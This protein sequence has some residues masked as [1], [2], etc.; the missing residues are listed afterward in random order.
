MLPAQVIAHFSRRQ[1]AQQPTGHV[2]HDP[3]ACR[4]SAESESPGE[5]Q[6]EEGEDEIPTPE[7]DL[8]EEDGPD[9]PRKITVAAEEE[10]GDAADHDRAFLTR[11]Q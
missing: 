10:L 8:D 4:D 5:E 1:R 11:Y 2:G 7:D 3:Y 6:R 9:R